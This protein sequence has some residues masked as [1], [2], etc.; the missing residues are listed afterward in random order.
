MAPEDGATRHSV[1]FACD[2]IGIVSVHGG[3]TVNTVS[4]LLP[5]G[6]ILPIRPMTRQRAIQLAYELSLLPDE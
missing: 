5:A 1:G 6:L 3:S 2:A 4:C